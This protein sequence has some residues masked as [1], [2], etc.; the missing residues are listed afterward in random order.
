MR[1]LGDGRPRWSAGPTAGARACGWPPG[2]RTTT[3]TASTRSGCPRARPTTSRPSRITFPSGRT[4][5]ELCPTEPP[6]LV[7][8]AQMGTLTFHPWPVRRA[9]VDHPDELRLDL[10]PQPGTTFAD[11]QRVADVARELLEELG[12]SRLPEDQR[13]PR[14]PHLRADRAAA[15]PSTMCGT[16]PSGFGRELERRDAGVTTNLVEGGA[17][18][19]DLPGLQPEHPGP[20]HRQRV[21][22]ARPARRAGRAR[23]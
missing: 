5:D 15:G 4:A 18:R 9:D 23:R 19:D 8:A 13:Q 11:A 20:H 16:P 17:R 21:E 6:S 22:P 12:H 2:H 1:A 7:W 10:D 14:D 3:A